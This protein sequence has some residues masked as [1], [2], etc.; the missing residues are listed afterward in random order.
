[1]PGRYNK[2]YL[3][4]LKELYDSLSFDEHQ[5]YDDLFQAVFRTGSATLASQQ[6]GKPATAIGRILWS[7]RDR[8]RAAEYSDNP[9]LKKLGIA[10]TS[11]VKG[12]YKIARDPK[13]NRSIKLRAYNDMLRIAGELGGNGSSK[14]LDITQQVVVIIGDDKQNVLDLLDG[15]KV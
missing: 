7:L 5:K 14:A 8:K 13:S 2:Q 12:L 15:G 6:L 4:D 3:E 9:V 11:L 10:N 1:M